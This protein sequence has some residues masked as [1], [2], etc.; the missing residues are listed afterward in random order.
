VITVAKDEQFRIV[1]GFSIRVT[2]E[3]EGRLA[4]EDRELGDG[5]GG[6]ELLPRE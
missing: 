6:E 2:T 1:S 4:L 3:A 5:A